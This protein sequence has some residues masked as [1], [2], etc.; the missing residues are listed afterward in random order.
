[1][2]EELRGYY[3]MMGFGI[4]F[5]GELVLGWITIASNLKVVSFIFENLQI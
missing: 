4:M 3:L 1:M 2:I 5:V